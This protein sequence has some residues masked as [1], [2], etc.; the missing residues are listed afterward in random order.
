MKLSAIRSWPP[1]V[2][3]GVAFAALVM[4]AGCATVV[5]DAPS[6]PAFEV[7]AQW[8]QPPADADATRA[9]LV[10]WWTAFDDPLLLELVDRALVHNTSV[11]AAQAALQQARAQRDLALAG[12][13]PVARASGSAQRGQTG[14]NRPGNTFRAG[15]DASWEPDLFGARQQAQAASEADV[16]V[17]AANLGQARVSLAAE[18]A[19]NAIELRGLQTR[20]RLSR[21]SLAAQQESLQLTAWRVQAGLA[22]ALDL[23]QAR[24]ASEQTAASLPALE[25]GIRQ[26]L[27]ALAVLTGQVPGT[28][29]RWLADRPAQ[30]VP[31]PPARLALGFPAETLR[32]RPDVRAAEQRVAAAWARVQQA[33]AQRHP[34]FS[35]SGSLGLTAP[36][37]GDLFDLSALTRSVLASVSASLFDGGAAR[38][39]VRVQQAV[40]EQARVGHEAAVLAA[41]RDVENALVAL[42]GNRERLARLQAAADAAANAESMARQRYASGLVDYR[43]LLDTQRTLLSARSELES[44]RATW[45]ADHVRLYKALGGGWSPTVADDSPASSS[46]PAT[47][48]S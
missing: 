8:G 38:A 14:D 39:Q 13:L 22:S 2:R 41:L 47:P 46:V 34:N 44:T 31:Q 9:G 24:A 42:Q 20:L 5:P 45:S 6:A 43:T 30:A 11:R 29:E 3:A 26:N 7:P 36:R 28:L 32:Q 25:T 15:F 17:A 33:D 27:N 19:L 4:L 10:Q 48:A 1:P 23:E 21:D 12:S 16:Q 35:L 37:I 18:V 40:L